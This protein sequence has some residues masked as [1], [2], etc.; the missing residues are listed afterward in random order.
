MWRTDYLNFVSRKIRADGGPGGLVERKA[1]PRRSNVGS[2]KFA[3]G[4]DMWSRWC[5]S[6]PNGGRCHE[7]IKQAFGALPEV[8]ARC[9]T[10]H[11]THNVIASY[12]QASWSRASFLAW[13]G[14]LSER[15]KQQGA[16]EDED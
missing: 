2:R 13:R 3:V 1:A 16:A 15:G 12:M 5:R 14:C 11:A 9:Y 10:V 8:E 6:G 4:S 7:R